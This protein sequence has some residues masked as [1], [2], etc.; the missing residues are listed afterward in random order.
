PERDGG[1]VGG[2]VVVGAEHTGFLIKDQGPLVT[3][4]FPCPG[5]VLALGDGDVAKSKVRV[6]R[7]RGRLV[8]PQTPEAADLQ[9]AQQLLHRATLER[10]ATVLYGNRLAAQVQLGGPSRA[11]LRQT[12]GSSPNHNH[13][14]A[15]RGAPRSL[16]ESL[17]VFGL[18]VPACCGPRGRQ[19]NRVGPGRQPFGNSPQNPLTRVHSA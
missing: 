10:R 5:A 15:P 7:E 4:L 9:A 2:R 11:P 1:E 17:L 3:S 14:H 8:R 19:D 18:I 6:G 13:Y 16:H 12:G